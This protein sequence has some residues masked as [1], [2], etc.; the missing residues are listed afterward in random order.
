M[1][2]KRG[3]I[4]TTY[5]SWDDPPRMSPFRK[6]DEPNLELP[7]SS[8]SSRS[9]LWPMAA[10]SHTEIQLPNP[11]Y[12]PVFHIWRPLTETNRVAPE[13]RP[14][15]PKRKFIFQPWI[16]RG[17]NVSFKGIPTQKKHCTSLVSLELVKLL[18]LDSTSTRGLW[19][20]LQKVKEDCWKWRNITAIQGA[21]PQM[22]P[23]PGNGRPYWGMM[24][25][26]EPLIIRPSFLGLWHGGGYF[27][28]PLLEPLKKVAVGRSGQGSFNHREGVAR[29]LGKINLQYHLN[30]ILLQ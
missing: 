30:T 29:T 17:E 4:L 24:V 6:G 23:L 1:T 27:G 12:P 13:N 20:A 9:T 2:C 11:P 7:S 28:D 22:L 16:F 8:E 5:K 3:M 19:M 21:H 10:F 15:R 26:N 25:V 18:M 14:K